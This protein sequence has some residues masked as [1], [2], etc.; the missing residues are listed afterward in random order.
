MWCTNGGSTFQKPFYE[1]P[2]SDS[3]AGPEFQ[4]PPGAL[5]RKKLFELC[6]GT[7]TMDEICVITSLSTR[8][9]MEFCN[10]EP[11]LHLL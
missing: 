2:H 4:T 3:S 10:S 7:R 9:I 1:K 6:D 11:N 8:E 5:A